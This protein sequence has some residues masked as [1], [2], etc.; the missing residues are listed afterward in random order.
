MNSTIQKVIGIYDIVVSYKDKIG[1][2]NRIPK[3]CY[4]KILEKLG[5]VSK[6]KNVSDLRRSIMKKLPPNPNIENILD[7][8]YKIKKIRNKQDRES[9]VNYLSNS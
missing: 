8:N 9:I 7:S 4:K 1:K 6:D 5:G 2:F 3:K